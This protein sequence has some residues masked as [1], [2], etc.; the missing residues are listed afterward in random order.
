MEIFN[1]V[2]YKNDDEQFFDTQVTLT[3]YDLLLPYTPDQA[4][5]S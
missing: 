2:S 3:E 5:F 1:E 4:L